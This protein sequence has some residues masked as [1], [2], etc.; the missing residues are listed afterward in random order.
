MGVTIILIL[1]LSAVAH[2]VRPVPV[3]PMRVTEEINVFVRELDVNNS[4][5]AAYI[6]LLAQN[7]A[8]DR[9]SEERTALSDISK[10]ACKKYIN[11]SIVPLIQNAITRSGT[12]W[13][14]RGIL[15]VAGKDKIQWNDIG[16]LNHTEFS[17]AQKE[18]DQTLAT[19]VIFEPSLSIVS[20][21]RKFSG[22]FGFIINRFLE[23][24]KSKEW[25]YLTLNLKAEV[26]QNGEKLDIFN[27][28]VMVPLAKWKRTKANIG[29]DRR[30]LALALSQISATGIVQEVLDIFT[31]ELDKG[32]DKKLADIGFELVSS[33][34]D[35]VQ[36]AALAIYQSAYRIAERLNIRR[37]FEQRVVDHLI[38]KVK[39]KGMGRKAHLLIVDGNDV[40][41]PDPLDLSRSSTKFRVVKTRRVYGGT[42]RDVLW[43]EI[44]IA[45]PF[46]SIR[47]YQ[48]L[49]QLLYQKY[50]LTE[51]DFDKDF[52]DGT[53]K[54]RDI[55][56]QLREGNRK[57]AECAWDVY[58]KELIKL[59]KRKS[60]AK[61]EKKEA[62]KEMDKDA[63]E[64][65]EIEIKRLN[66]E[67]KTIKHKYQFLY[68]LLF[69]HNYLVI[70]LDGSAD[71][72]IKNKL[73]D[74]SW[75]VEIAWDW[76]IQKYKEK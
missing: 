18:L 69:R 65:S 3:I 29:I 16:N 41:V 50:G 7:D 30:V 22:S 34:V 55:A 67:I 1:C 59:A 23:F 8:K 70:I 25:V 2:A 60:T 14:I 71:K 57:D 51:H 74:G 54:L 24:E 76:Y 39:L 72:K 21:L 5:I 19:Y 63:I 56:S 40:Y 28:F 36:A 49:L 26:H 48:L 43:G 12:F 62:E 46:R 15:P 66:A 17:D 4:L 11:G 52:D 68:D 33:E 27:D 10:N 44:F 32:D 53:K 9:T 58:K 64:K 37:P 38:E 45:Q 47:D 6:D 13:K 42:E 35:P 75:M 73:N 61:D 20:G 31:E